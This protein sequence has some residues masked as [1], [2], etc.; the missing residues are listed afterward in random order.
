MILDASG[1]DLAI[2]EYAASIKLWL[3][4]LIVAKMVFPFED[5]GMATEIVVTAF[6]M[7]AVNV[8]VGIIESVMARCRFS[9]M[10]Q[11][12]YSAGVIA[13]IAFFLSISSVFTTMAGGR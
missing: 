10:P 6:L 7:I 9:K 11:L 4:S 8:V 2:F 3:F 1:P 5:A 13:L 12:M